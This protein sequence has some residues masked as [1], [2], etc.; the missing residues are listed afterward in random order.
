MSSHE[1]VSHKV[2]ELGNRRIVMFL[3]S[4]HSSRVARGLIRFQPVSRV[5]VATDVVLDNHQI[6]R[7]VPQPHAQPQR[8]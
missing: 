6:H 3:T 2:Q 1:P 8:Q 7:P 4:E 5:S